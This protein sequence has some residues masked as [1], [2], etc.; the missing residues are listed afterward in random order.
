MILKCSQCGN[1]FNKEAPAQDDV[2]VCP[3]CDS[4]YIAVVKAGKLQLKDYVFEEKDLG[5]L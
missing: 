3:I 2:V 4:Q 5:Q 1:T